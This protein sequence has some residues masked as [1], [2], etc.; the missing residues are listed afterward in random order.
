MQYDYL[1]E[2]VAAAPETKELQA[3]LNRATIPHYALDEC[4]VWY[5]ALTQAKLGGT[6]DRILDFSV[7]G[8][9]EMVTKWHYNWSPELISGVFCTT[10]RAG[11]IRRVVGAKFGWKTIE[12]QVTSKAICNFPC[13]SATQ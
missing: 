12:G 8:R 2:H 1:W 6:H 9:A 11:P 3:G 5:D 10:F 4:P 7:W 13:L